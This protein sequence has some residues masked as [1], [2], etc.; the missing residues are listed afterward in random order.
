MKELSSE[1]DG[2]VLE[3]QINKDVSISKRGREERE[4][5]A[6]YMNRQPELL[7]NFN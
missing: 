4:V 2:T 5:D 1:E 6:R 7:T 3:V